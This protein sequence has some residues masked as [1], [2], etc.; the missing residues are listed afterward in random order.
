M[1]SVDFVCCARNTV[2][3]EE[4]REL[5]LK[6]E[7]WGW[8]PRGYLLRSEEPSGSCT[9]TS[10]STPPSV[11]VA[12]QWFQHLCLCCRF[13]LTPVIAM[14]WRSQ[15]GHPRGWSFHSVRDLQ[16][17]L[18]TGA[19]LLLF[20]QGIALSRSLVLY[21]IDLVLVLGTWIFN[22]EVFYMSNNTYHLLVA[23]KVFFYIIKQRYRKIP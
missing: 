8:R 6:T 22:I 4:N 18:R 12:S 15:A 19:S 17:G 7:P 9:P 23:L 1:H 5:F 14:T 2:S 16:R 20:S 10:T 3:R 11:S 13:L 21:H